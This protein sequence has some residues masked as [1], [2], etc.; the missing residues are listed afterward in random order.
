LGGCALRP[1]G[2]AAAK[3][4]TA[5]Q[6]IF[7]ILRTFIA[8]FKFWV[9]VQPWEG[10]IRV[11]FGRR[12]R[13]LEPGCHLMLPFYLDHIVDMDVVTQVVSTR[14][15][16]IQTRDNHTLAIEGELRYRIT[17]VEWAATRVQH[18]DDTLVNL[19]VG[20]V[21]DVVSALKFPDCKVG[22]LRRLVL[23]AVREEC[24]GW[25]VEIER[26]YVASLC[27]HKAYRVMGAAQAAPV[28]EED[29]WAA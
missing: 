6:T 7:D 8:A 25:G 24:E 17:N 20:V 10:A 18:L 5:M 1:A 13:V 29:E 19:T 27:E 14:V 9:I 3:T 15:Q 2:T 12:V 26:F 22:P 4:G 21:A 11:R 16:S 28:L 23:N